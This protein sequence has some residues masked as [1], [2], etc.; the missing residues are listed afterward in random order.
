MGHENERRVELFRIR[1]DETQ[2]CC[3]PDFVQISTQTEVGVKVQKEGAASFGG[4]F[5]FLVD[6]G[7]ASMDCST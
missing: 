7:N 2:T 3:S 4:T 5:H 1:N 6:V